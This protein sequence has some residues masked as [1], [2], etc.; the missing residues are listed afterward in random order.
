MPS[1]GGDP[2]FVTLVALSIAIKSWICT[3]T[4]RMVFVQCPGILGQYW[5]SHLSSNGHTAAVMGRDCSA[6]LAAV[7]VKA[8]L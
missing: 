5:S 7:R 8:L 3:S 2:Q 6:S 1:R 4:R